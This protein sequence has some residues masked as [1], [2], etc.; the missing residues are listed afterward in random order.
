MHPRCGADWSGA[1]MNFQV[2]V[3]KILVSYPDGFAVM[4]DLKRDMATWRP[5]V[6]NGRT[7]PS[8]WPPGF[9]ISTSSRSAYSSTI[10][11]PSFASTSVAHQTHGVVEFVEHVT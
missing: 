4:E 9:R 10:V 5:A 6:A 11:G 1:G 2:L 3:L 7:G 8:G